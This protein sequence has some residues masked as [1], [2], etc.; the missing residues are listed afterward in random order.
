MSD[1]T[2]TMTVKVIM[3][4]KGKIAVHWSVQNNDLETLD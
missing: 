1:I 4:V 2:L 3:T